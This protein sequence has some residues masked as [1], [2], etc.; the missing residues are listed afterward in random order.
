MVGV[1]HRHTRPR[2]FLR[3]SRLAPRVLAL[4]ASLLAGVTA[5]AAPPLEAPD[6]IRVEQRG[7]V[8]Q[9]SW[10]DAEERLQGALQPDPP[11]AGEPLKVLLN[12]GS[13]EGAAFEGP[14]TLTLR[15]AGATHGEVKTVT[16]GAV[17]WHAEFIPERAGPYRLDVSFR[18]TRH[19]VLHADFEVL[20]P[21]V[22]R[23]IL[24]S[25]VGLM[26]A[27]ALALGIRSLVRKDKPPEIHPVLAELQAQPEK[28][29]GSTPET[30]PSP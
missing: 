17:N 12:V 9:L 6:V 4:S 28:P 21:P 19:K 27:A 23:F 22:P 2:H 11:R 20:R 16:K 26:A 3:Q 14:L 13:F 29:T 1:R 15:E 24:W 5:L 7:D 8:L 10:S 18:T 30:P 25:G